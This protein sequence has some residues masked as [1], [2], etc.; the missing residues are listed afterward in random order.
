M[1]RV[2]G[3]KQ[4]KLRGVGKLAGVNIGK[5]RNRYSA[6]RNCHWGKKKENCTLH[7]GAEVNR[8]CSIIDCGV[9]IY[10]NYLVASPY[11]SEA[12]VGKDCRGRVGEK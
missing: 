7:T 4:E 8:T 10:H 3:C 12:L 1:A 9:C 11:G 2:E 6:M 5:R